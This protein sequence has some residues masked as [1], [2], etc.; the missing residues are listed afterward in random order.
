MGLHQVLLRT[1]QPLL[2]GMAVL[3][4][5]MLRTNS[6][7]EKSGS[8]TVC[9]YNK[10][11]DLNIKKKTTQAYTTIY[12]GEECTVKKKRPFWLERIQL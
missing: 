7:G 3:L 11:P 12:Q 8:G 2:P 9:L 6:F 10:C 5:L 4:E 1:L